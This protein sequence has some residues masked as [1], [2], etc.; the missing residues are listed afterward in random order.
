VLLFFVASLL[1]RLTFL[2]VMLLLLCVGVALPVQANNDAS[3]EQIVQQVLAANGLPNTLIQQTILEKSADLNAYTDGKK[4]V[5]TDGLWSKLSTN[6]EKAFVLSHEMAH[7][8]L[9]HIQKTQVRKFGLGAAAQLLGRFTGNQPLLLG[10]QIGLSLI[11]KKFSRN[12][13]TQADELGIQL[14]RKANYNPKAA[15]SVFRILQAQAGSGN[16]PEFMQ[17]HPIPESRI[18]DLARKYQL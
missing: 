13:E 11:D 3:V 6:D 14:M 10:S 9:S 15:I 16:T 18:Q 17:S 7:V 2:S 4:I 5:V 12:M 8:T 1:K